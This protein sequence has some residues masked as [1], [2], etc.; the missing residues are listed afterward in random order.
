MKMVSQF[1]LIH[2]QIENIFN[3]NTFSSFVSAELEK[4]DDTSA[5][6]IKRTESTLCIVCQKTFS[7][8]GRL[9]MHLMRKHSVRTDQNIGAKYK[10]EKCEKTYS[11]RANLIIHERTHSGIS[12]VHVD[13]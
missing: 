7:S 12:R 5:V 11:T 10:C 2:L 8:T 6:T 9:Q 4:A 3:M 13:R 1:N